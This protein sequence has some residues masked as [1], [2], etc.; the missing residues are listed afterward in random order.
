M[1]HGSIN[2]FV[3]LCRLWSKAASFGKVRKFMI[4]PSKKT[5][6]AK[7][8]WTNPK[9]FKTIPTVDHHASRTKL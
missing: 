4:K 1:I 7:L 9:L 8:V 2:P 6:H 3:A 5:I